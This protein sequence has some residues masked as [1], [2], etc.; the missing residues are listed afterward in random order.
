MA[1]IDASNVEQFVGKTI[2]DTPRAG[3]SG[4]WTSLRFGA[5]A[6]LL[7]SVITVETAT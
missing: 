5:G 3:L 4:E 1:W 7:C 2:D 6:R